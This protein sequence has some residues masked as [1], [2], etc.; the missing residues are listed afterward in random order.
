MNQECSESNE[1]DGTAFTNNLWRI[2]TNVILTEI[3]HELFSLA[4]GL[5]LPI[6]GILVSFLFYLAGDFLPCEKL[7]GVLRIFDIK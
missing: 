4:I 6:F 1:I 2:L 3:V 7:L 5:I